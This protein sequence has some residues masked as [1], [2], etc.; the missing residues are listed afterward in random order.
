[1][2]LESWTDPRTKRRRTGVISGNSLFATQKI[3]K[4]ET[5][6]VKAGKLV[7]EAYLIKHA[8]LVRGAQLQIAR[9]LFLAPTTEEEWNNTLIGVNH[10]CEP[11]CYF[12]GDIVFRALRDIEPG[13][14]I[15]L[16]YATAF[17]TDTESF[18]CN[19]GSKLCRG[20][21]KPSSDWQRKDIQKRFKGKFSNYVQSLIDAR[22]DK[23]K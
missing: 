7:G 20:I 2:K 22:E 5:I 21:I 4:D 9:D 17:T 23:I 10:S 19:C 13:E 6:A 16:D 15:T 3:K 11:N 8:A 12:D 14:E 1:M 18:T